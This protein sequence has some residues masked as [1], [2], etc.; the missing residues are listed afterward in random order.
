[1]VGANPL[2]KLAF[3][4]G[5]S[6]PILSYADLSAAQRGGCANWVTC[7]ALGA[8]IVVDTQQMGPKR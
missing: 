2:A 8:H 6:I 4:T 7:G 1:M 5:A 3:Y